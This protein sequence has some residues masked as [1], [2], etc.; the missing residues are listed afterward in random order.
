MS[1]LPACFECRTRSSLAGVGVLSPRCAAALSLA[2]GA[3]SIEM[4][5]GIFL[6]RVRWASIAL[7]CG[8]RGKVVRFGLPRLSFLKS[9]IGYLEAGLSDL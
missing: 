3:R 1:T 5:S 8:D 6:C 7:G 9:P 4:T 2:G